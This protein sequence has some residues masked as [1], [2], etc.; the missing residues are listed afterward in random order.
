MSST[1]RYFEKRARSFDRVYARPAALRRGPLRG[2]EL[3]AGVVAR[4]PGASVLDV[5]CGPGRVAEAALEAGARSYV[6]IDLSP[7]MLSLASARLA[8][9]D[10][11]ELREGDFLELRPG[12]EFDVVLA[13]GVFEYLREPAR[14]AAWLR[15]ACSTVLV[16]SFT[17]RDRVKAPLRR[18][19]YALHGCRLA[20]ST[21]E[22]AEA[23]LGAAGFGTVDFPHRGPRG[24]LVVAS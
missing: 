17:R 10:R 13:L 11:V 6:G 8:R 3:A 20:D 12:G 18:V 24:F 9:F 5:G 23:L 4:H 19:H 7:R 15:S 16:A 14:A 1:R 2:R 22:R 21:E